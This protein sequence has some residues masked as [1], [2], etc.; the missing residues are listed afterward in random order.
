MNLSRKF[1]CAAA[2]MFVTVAFAAGLA[3]QDVAGTGNKKATSSRKAADAVERKAPDTKR[4]AGLEEVLLALSTYHP[5]LMQ[6]ARELGARLSEARSRHRAYP[7][8]R[9]GLAWT[10]A[11][12]RKDLAYD[13]QRTPMTGFEYRLSQPIPFPGRLTTKA[14]LADLDAR[15]KRLEL[16]AEKNRLTR[17]LLSHLVKSRSLRELARLTESYASRIGITAET[18]RTRYAVG[19][20][21]LADLSR[22]ELM[23]SRYQERVV[24]LVGRRDEEARRVGYFLEPLQHDRVLGPKVDGELDN[25]ET[26]LASYLRFLDTVRT[27]SVTGLPAESVVVAMRDVLLQ[28]GQT[29]KSL[30]AFEYLPDMELF[31]AYRV[32]ANI[33]NDPVRG[34]DFFSF[35]VM[36][37]IPLWSAFST[38]PL[39]DAREQETRAA[40]HA[41]RD[42]SEE[43]QALFRAL[44]VRYAT[45][46][47]RIQMYEQRLIPQARRARDSARQ[48][49]ETGKVDFEVLLVSWDALYM[50]EADLVRLRAE[51]DQQVLRMADL[52]NRILPD[53]AGTPKKTGEKQ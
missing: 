27:R 26:G 39:R 45:L 8:P 21:N 9:V 7:D 31:A 1:A 35:G 32:R 14:K 44:T 40:Q 28:R 29:A 15:T 25:L 18:A 41:R 33:P 46:S 47:E 13:D 37:R 48:A 23:Y 10:N 34:E 53:V 42:A 49:Y 52:Y 36:F 19:R 50:R 22:A 12:Y 4:V 17:T 24:N 11:P 20:G 5:R 6:K 51:R 3:A 16:I 2:S 43:V 30:A 38:P